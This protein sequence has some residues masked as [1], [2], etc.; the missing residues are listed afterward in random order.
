MKINWYPGHMK[1]TRELIQKN[2]NL[3]DIVIEIVD[4]RIPF[5]SRNPIIDEMINNK[6]KIVV[7]NKADLADEKATD[8]WISYYKNKG[9]EV[10]ALNSFKG[11]RVKK[12]VDLCR[13]LMEEK[14]KRDRKRGR[15]NTVIRAMIVGIPNV[16]KSTFINKLVGKKSARIGNKPGVTRGKQWIKVK[17]DLEFLDTPGILWPNIDDEQVGL[18]LAYV[19]SIRDDIMD[20]EKLTSKLIDVLKKRYPETLI[21]AYGDL[22]LDKENYDI[23]RQIA[24]NKNM[25]VKGNNA[26]TL[27]ATRMILNDFRSSKLKRITLEL[28]KDISD[29]DE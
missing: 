25:L 15:I 5:S 17:K 18:K 20:I 8:K 9:A 26:D 22:D 13:N 24:I 16:G 2:L 28:P 1:K 7:L 6:K 27:K 23:I 29:K 19:G 21:Q 10:I 3:V 14:I 12:I 4:A 11:K